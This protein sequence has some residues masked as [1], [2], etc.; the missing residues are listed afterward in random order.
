LDYNI[1]LVEKKNHTDHP[2][3]IVTTTVCL[4]AYL[5]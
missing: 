4:K 3:G 2:D 5:F 1:F